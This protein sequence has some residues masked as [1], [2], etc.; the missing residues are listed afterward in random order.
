MRNVFIIIIC[1]VAVLS[2]KGQ[3]VP[4]L[5]RKVDQEKMNHWADSVFD[6]LSFDERIGQLIMVIANPTTDNRNMQRLT[7]YVNE[8]K[9]GG[10]LFHKGN[11]VTQAD[12]TNRVQ[13]IAKLPLLVSL[14]GE[15]GLSMRLSGTTRFPKNM[16]LGAIEDNSLIEAYGKEVG[17]QCREMG[18]H[19]NFAPSMDVNSNMENPVIGLRSF[20]EDP[21]AVSEKGIAYAR[22]IEGMNVLSVA[23]HFPG[24]G[25]TSEDSHHTLPVVRHDKYRLDSLELLPFKRYIYE[26]FGGMMTGHL[27]VPA[28]DKTPNPASLSHTIVS[29]LLKEQLG[30]QG[31]YFTDALAM[32]GASTKTKDNISVKALLAGNDILLASATPI[33]DFE[34]IKNAINEGILD[35]QEIEAKCLKILRY[36]YIL[37][38]NQYK[39]VAIKGLSDRINSSHAEWLASR[40]NA[41][42][43]TLLKND[44]AIIPLKELNKK[45]IAVLSIGDV[46]GNEFQQMLNRYDSVACFSIV[47]SSNATHIQRVYNQLQQYDLIICSI[48]TVRIP[49]APALKQLAEKKEV[50]FSFFTLPYFC[51][52]YSSTKK[53]KALIM[54]YE[55]TPLAMKFAA[56]LIFGGIPAKGKLPVSIPDLYF[57]GTGIF[58]EKTRLG[59][60]EPEEVGMNAARLEVIDK[61]VAEGLEEK[62]YPGCQV[63]IAKEGQIIYHKSFG[64]FDFNK[65]QRVT[66]KSV[67]DLASA[68]KAAGTLLAVINAFDEKKFTLESKISDYIPSLKGS[69]KEN[70][71]IKELLY[72]QSGLI[73]TINFYLKAI[74]PDSY[75]GSLYSNTKSTSFPARFDAKTYARNDFSFLPNLVSK[76]P[77]EGFSTKVAH[78]FYLHDS[79]KDTIIQTIKE[80]KLGTRGKYAYSC[81]NFILLKMM[82]ENQLNQPMDQLLNNQFY[83]RLGA[84]R[85][86]YNPLHTIDSLHIV[87]TENDQFLRRQLLRG[88]VHDEAAAFQGG[89][90]GNAGLFSNANDLAKVVAIFLNQGVYGDERF[91][92]AESCLLFT[93]SKSPTCHRGLGFDKPRP[94]NPKASSCGELAPKS[95]YGH[96]GFTG[97]CFWVDP[98]NQLIYIFLSNRV[99]PT[100]ANNKLST[101]DIRTRIQDAIYKSFY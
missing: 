10:I 18:I 67:Y 7:R 32:K 92:S 51:K 45:K 68:S 53:A 87:P 94:D 73:P 47:Q 13:K 82:V 63:L 98:E 83:S 35:L 86:T 40:L 30:F 9:I 96:T 90:S 74:D 2:A 28:L 42:A 60:H 16:M 77:K 39:P 20:G 71:K 8:I 4:E 95:V 99:N 61:I 54:G 12:V 76:S 93:E 91:L 33:N 38:L 37:G 79:F 80:S 23:K 75:Q 29:G 88:H 27:H 31:L 52:D 58:T 72:H 84:W 55:A 57:A 65:S 49:E 21:D 64:Y 69:N 34:A 70:L 62:A 15:W 78:H 66:E 36:K 14:D 50:I 3:T 89:V 100:R 17:R 48:H 101:L 25:D 19:I 44:S 6:T 85:M 81:I 26:G 56:Q 1:C 11:P 43:I 22:G 24:H 46:V 59:Y 5:Y 41:E 97:T